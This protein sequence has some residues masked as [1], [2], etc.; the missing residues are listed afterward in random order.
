M[1]DTDIKAKARFIV[2]MEP[3]QQTI[4][5]AAITRRQQFVTTVF[6]VTD[7]NEYRVFVGSNGIAQIAR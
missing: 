3:A 2:S 6:V 1:T 4:E 5:S 7:R